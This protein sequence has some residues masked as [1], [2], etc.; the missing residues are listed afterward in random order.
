M[1]K[2]TDMCRA[3][4]DNIDF[5]A[6]SPVGSPQGSPFDAGK[7]LQVVQSSLLSMPRDYARAYGEPLVAALPNL[8]VEIKHEHDQQVA[9]GRDPG[10]ALA[11]A[12]SLV[13]TI[14]GA[15]RDWTEPGYV[16][17]L[18]RFEAV[19]SNLYRSFLSDAQRAKVLLPLIETV[20][21]LATFAPTAD[22]GPFTLPADATKQ[23]INIPIGIVS[24]PG[25]Y[26][27]HPLVWPA[28][29][30]EC[31]G[32]DV[33]HA[34]PGLLGELAQGAASLP[35]LPPNVGRLWAGWMD[36]A[37]SDVY[38][39]LNVGPA[40]AVS[41]AAFFSVLRAGG[42]GGQ[43][44]P[45]SNILPI[46]DN[47]PA[48]VHPVDILRVHLAIGVTAQLTS[49]SASRKA[50]WLS[51]LQNLAVEAAGGE[52]TIDVV[53]VAT[54]QLVQRLPL[55][56]MAQAAQAIGGFIATSRLAALGGKSIQDIE[57]WDDTDDAAAQ[58]I[59]VAATEGSSLINL[60]DDAQLLAGTTMALLDNSGKYGSI[61]PLLEAALDDSYARDPV[62]AP[63]AAFFM[64]YARDRRRF[65]VG[66][67][68][69]P[70]FPLFPLQA[71]DNTV[72]DP[73]TPAV[74]AVTGKRSSLAA[75]QSRPKRAK[76]S[77]PRVG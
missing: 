3:F 68:R 52:T 39:L 23:L 58:T 66:Y 47:A 67:S 51:V 4:A 11:D 10:E 55:G 14:V 50:T 21:P 19:I 22:Q 53:D 17:P 37:A 34:D 28:L 65:G 9:Q 7:L 32:H 40:F 45:I 76:S 5:K 16:A 15:C 42:G 31:G 71:Q 43:L 25:S 2:Y 74:I 13:D 1:S 26:R 75:A 41:L 38:G 62:F 8:I 35:H 59:K 70:T 77:R 48:D 61:T 27:D 69:T 44:G 72:F 18:K 6:A 49:L 57:T 36:E 20:P 29:A 46:Q 12:K 30:H 60:G 33:L 56:P 54:E 64:L 63:P 73:E 24:L